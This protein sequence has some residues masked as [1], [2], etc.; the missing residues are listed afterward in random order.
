MIAETILWGAIAIVAY[1]YVGYPALIYLLA[2]VRP[3][4]V[5]KAPGEPSVTFII[6]AY[7]EE[8]AIAE[9]LQN[10]LAVDYPRDRLEIL[11]ASDGSTDRTDEIVETEFAGRARLIAVAGR[12]GKTLAQNR[13]VEHARG[14]IL[15]FSDATTVYRPDTLRALLANYA[16]PEV[17]CVTGWLV[18]GIE[19][20]TAIH[21]GRAAYTDYEQWQRIHESRFASIL[22]ACGA[23]YSLRRSLYTHLPADVTSDFSQAV[24]VVEQGY[25]AIIDAEAVAFEAGEGSDIKDELERRTRI[26]TRG[27]RGQYYVRHFF[28]PLRHP[29]FCFQTLSHRL[30]R[31]A[32]PIFMII[33]FV[34]NLF[35]IDRPLY[36]ILLAGQLVFYLAAAVGYALERRGMRPRVL[37]LP[38]YFCVVNLAPLLALRALLRG[39]KKVVWETRR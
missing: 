1:V 29:W 37:L 16:D 36:A 8:K 21:R 23:I 33:A 19:K 11:V 7:N 2:S 15:V 30:L 22:G 38:L 12:G 20:G 13:T 24:K 5:H 3:R 31:W 32:V 4:P 35:L 26:A 28:N 34:A 10:T 6:A 18:M 27:L 25:R 9:K 17:G 39:D 14:D